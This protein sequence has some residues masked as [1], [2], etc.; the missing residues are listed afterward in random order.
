MKKTGI[1]LALTG[2]MLLCASCREQQAA[3]AGGDYKLLHV[4]LS[5]R[6]LYS[7]FPATIQGKQ[8]VKIYPQISGLVTRVCINEGDNVRKGQTLFVIDQTPYKATLEKARANVETAEANVATAQ[9]TVDSKEKL[10]AEKVVSSFD[11]RQA[12]NTLRS[13]KAS[14]AQA[15]ADLT[16]AQNDLS[17]TE[18]KSPVNGTAGMSPYRIGSLVNPSIATPLVCVSDNAEMFAYFSM[19]EKQVLALSR[20]NG[21]LKNALHAMP[22]VELLLSD[23]DEYPEKGKVDAIS[24]IVD[25]STGSV[26]LRAVF[27]NK[28][29]ILR[30]GSTGNIRLSQK[31]T[32]CIVIPQ[33]A[34]YELQDKVFVYKVVDGKTQS[35]QVTVVECNNGQE[36]VVEKGLAVGDVIIA[37]GAGLLRD[38]MAVGK[39]KDT[40]NK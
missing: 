38:G 22:E 20:Q 25:T 7:L 23:G 6:T 19:S 39:A 1:I 14:L 32:G 31:R 9:M 35:A 12:R 40:G 33:A 26:A 8:D 27:P 34:T 4:T 36:Y 37:E 2:V 28:D 3:P 30:S 15:R 11:L 21:S 16:N 29:C 24:G 17:Y 10:F 18:V 13:A 5:E